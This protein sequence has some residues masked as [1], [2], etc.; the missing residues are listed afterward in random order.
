MLFLAYTIGKDSDGRSFETDV[1]LGY[2]LFANRLARPVIS[3]DFR[4]KWV[5][6]VLLEVASVMEAV[7]PYADW[8][9]FVS[10]SKALMSIYWF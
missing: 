3:L 2:L 5:S 7:L 10:S 1:D 9:L 4:E 8:L 6:L